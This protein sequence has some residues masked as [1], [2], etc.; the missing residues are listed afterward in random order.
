LR[1]PA[2]QTN[3]PECALVRATEDVGVLL[4]REALER[5]KQTWLGR[6]YVN[7]RATTLPGSSFHRSVRFHA[8][9]GHLARDHAACASPWTQLRV[10]GLKPPTHRKHA[11]ADRW[12]LTVGSSTC[13]RRT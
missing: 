9:A 5:F 7:L 10:G 3:K 11:L 6:G 8:F 1:N 13:G 2:R 12:F 4:S